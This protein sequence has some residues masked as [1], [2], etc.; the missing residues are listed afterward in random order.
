[1]SFQQALSGL[2]AAAQNLDVIGNNVSNANTVGFKSGTAEFADVY[3]NALNGT[4]G[5]QVGIGTTVSGI[6]QQFTQGSI[7]STNNPLD[8][9]ISGGGFFRM[10]SSDNTVTYSRNGQ[11]SVNNNNNIISSDGLKLTGYPA[12]SSGNIIKSAPQVLQLS[13]NS[14]APITTSAVTVSSNLDANTPDLLPANFNP[15]DPSTYT[16]STSTN[17]FDS[18]GNSHV[19]SLYW[20]KTD[21][22][23]NTWN[24]YGAIDG[25]ALASNPIE[26]MAFDT[27]GSMSATTL[28]AQPVSITASVGASAA[29]LTFTLDQTGTTQFGSSFNVNNLNQ[30]GYAS[31][32]LT[33]FNIGSNGNILGNYSN[34]QT[35]TLGQV[36][37]ADFV[38]QQ[39]LQPNGNNQFSETADSGPPLVGTPGTGTLGVLQS[40]AVEQS[41]VDLTTELVN[42]ITAQR[43]YQAN[44][45]SIKTEDAILQTI[46]S[47]Q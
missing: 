12:D 21:T 34:G 38:D 18:L 11:F 15:S 41:N 39:A 33:G 40:S 20:M 43:V 23:T 30:N 42:M 26:T 7:T 36:A 27:N 35:L 8:L 28:A 4:G 44:A 14:L 5:S 9:A 24:V 37:L 31:G 19:L 47:L 6:S 2:N 13:R 22:S 45:Q 46:T 3:A 10:S 1:M 32:Q 29:P 25:T 17:V 16:S